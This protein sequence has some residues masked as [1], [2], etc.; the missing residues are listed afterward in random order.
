MFAS[1]RP[2]SSRPV[3]KDCTLIFA[4]VK[5]LA[6]FNRQFLV[7]LRKAYGEPNPPG[8]DS[9]VSPVYRDSGEWKRVTGGRDDAV[10]AAA[11]AVAAAAAA[12]SNRLLEEDPFKPPTAPDVDRGP[13]QMLEVFLKSA[14]FLKVILYLY[15]YCLRP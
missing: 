10:A 3:P 4:N 14:P 6:N 11:A 13:R 2:V 15:L 1:S 7:D 8:H 5:Q 12:A 9:M